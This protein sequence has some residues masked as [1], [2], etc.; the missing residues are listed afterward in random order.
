MR[1]RTHDDDDD[2]GSTF[3]LI[4]LTRVTVIVFEMDLNYEMDAL[5]MQWTPCS[6]EALLNMLYAYSMDVFNFSFRLLFTGLEQLFQLGTR[7]YSQRMEIYIS[8][9]LL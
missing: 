6:M 5:L 4:L 8:G 3:G 1:Q 9:T 2:D 7:L